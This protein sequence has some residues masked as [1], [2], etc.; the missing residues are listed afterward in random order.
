M[1]VRVTGPI[2]LELQTVF[3]ADWYLE[4]EEILDGPE[5]FPDPEIT[6]YIPAQV[7]PSGPGYPTENN[8]RLLV[9]LIHA[10]REK[11]VITTPYFIPDEP[12]LQAMQTAVLRGAEVH[13]ICSKKADQLLVSLAQR[14]YYGELLDA[15]V[16]IHL[17][18]KNFLHAKHLSFDDKVAVIGSSNM[19]IRSFALN[20]EIFSL[21]YDKDFTAKLRAE[22]DRYLANCELLNREKWH[23]RPMLSKVMQHL[24][25]LMSP[26]L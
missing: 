15:G 21:F 24:A 11:V 6:G 18:R 23:Q 19:D 26:L 9:T 22:E 5:I 14:S 2:V 1:V 7:L 13:L 8:Q 12:I 20:A 17:Y 25:R 3:V 10:A 4:M 16:K